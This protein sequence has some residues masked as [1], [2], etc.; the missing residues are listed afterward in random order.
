MFKKVG[1]LLLV[2]LIATFALV[3]CGP[4]EPAGEGTSAISEKHG[5]VLHC[6]YLP[7]TKM[8]P[9]FISM[10]AEGQ[11]ARQWA[12]YLVYVD[13]DNEPDVKRGLAEH[14]DVDETG[15][16]W[17]FK[18]REGVKFHDGKELTS[19]DVQFTFDRL[20]DP[21][22]GAVT[23]D[24]YSGIEDISVHDDYTVVFK[25]KDTNPDFLMDLGDYHAVILDADSSDYDTVW[26]GTG[27]FFIEKY[28]PEDRIILKRNPNYW[29]KDQN[30]LALP[31]LDGIELLFLSD[32]SAQVEALRSGQV[33]YLIHLP[34]E[35]VSSIGDDPNI[36]I[37][38]KPSNTT[39][40]IRFRS[41][42]PPADDVRVRQALKAGTDNTAILEGAILGLGVVGYNTPFGP[43]H[44]D[45]FLKVPE[46]V[47][48]VEK[49][50]KLLA[51]AGYADGLEITIHVQEQSPV[52]AMATIWKEQMA[53]IGVTVNIQLVPADI[54][55]GADDMWLEVDFGITDWSA[56]PYPQPYLDLAYITSAPWNECHW[57][58]PEI[59]ELAAL[60][61]KE[62][63]HEERVRIYH[64]VQEIFI[65]RGPVII[66]FFLDNLWGVRTNV[67]GIQ[68]TSYLGFALDLRLVY[69]EE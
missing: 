27:P 37:F 20:R 23:L 24:L 14:W 45:Y 38:R 1:V 12:D 57:S 30:D 16:V 51:D 44:G 22:V 55:F 62:M 66:P 18:I 41:D 15:T 60:A 61:A 49:A 4:S 36:N 64:R 68:P 43:T 50:K 26:N 47:R 58:D 2:I 3:S 39:Y 33:D 28:M 52:P 11:I 21:D 67:K 19:R 56:R 69:L 7:P 32:P 48:D 54:Y 31:Y 5:G 6:A 42:R 63:D 40:A 13:E 25:L 53:E 29:L 34:A 8:D 9:A 65:E 17:T 46:P 59:D 35:L 10:I